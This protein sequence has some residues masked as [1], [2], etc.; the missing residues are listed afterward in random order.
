QQWKIVNDLTGVCKDKNVDRV[1]LDNG[2]L[3]T[4]PI[5]VA[6][7]INKYLTTIQSVQECRVNEE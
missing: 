4:D 6:E 2:V 3:I 1:E 7:Q 5:I